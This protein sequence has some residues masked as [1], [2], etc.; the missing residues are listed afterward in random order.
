MSLWVSI[1]AGLVWAALWCQTALFT[2]PG[3][4]D[5]TDRV[6]CWLATGQLS[7]VLRSWQLSKSKADSSQCWLQLLQVSPLLTPRLGGEKWTHCFSE[8]S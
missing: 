3:W 5:V 6:G 4:A 1:L 7:M 8:R 2:G